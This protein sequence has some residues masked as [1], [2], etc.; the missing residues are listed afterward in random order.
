MTACIHRLIATALPCAILASAAYAQ[1][2]VNGRRDFDYHPAPQF[3]SADVVPPVVSAAGGTATLNVVL[4]PALEEIAL[5]VT[6]TLTGVDLDGMQTAGTGDNVTE[7][8]IYRGAAGSN[9]PLVFGILGPANSDLNMDTTVDPVNG[10]VYT[11][12][13]DIEGNA[14]SLFTQLENLW[15]SQI[16]ILVSTNDNPTG[17]IRAQVQFTTA[18]AVQDNFTQFGN[19]TSGN[20]FRAEGGSEL[21]AAYGQMVNGRLYV[22]TTGNLE[23]NFNKYEMFI[24]CLP[25]GQNKLRGDNPDVDFNGINR[26]GD[27]GSDNGLRFDAGFEADHWFSCTTGGGDDFAMPPIPPDIFANYARLLTGGGGT[28]GFMGGNPAPGGQYSFSGL[29]VFLGIDQRNTVGVDGSDV[30]NPLEVNTGIEWSI[31]LRQLGLPRGEVKICVFINGGGHDFLSNQ[32]LGGLGG[33]SDN[34]GEPRNVDFGL[35]SGLQYFTLM[36]PMVYGDLNK[37]DAVQADD[38]AAFLPEL[39]K[40]TNG[41]ADLEGDGKVDAFDLA[42]L[43]GDLSS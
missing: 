27:D 10:V 25:G 3:S 8:A 22:L 16:Y 11:K 28:G 9:G 15:A 14:T 42:L 37:N 33:L 29:P 41:I 40:T 23:S 30:N 32:V 34:L 43:L 17:E 31:S 13:D 2:T 38:L 24:D 12:W 6:L 36:L 39:G 35:Q 7:V 21:N 1:P 4:S 26:M 18:L 19:S 20:P 5:E